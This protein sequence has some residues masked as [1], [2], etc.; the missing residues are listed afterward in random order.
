MKKIISIILPLYMLSFNSYA[1]PEKI[2]MIF[3]S[4]H[5]VSQLLELIE[6]N[7]AEKALTLLAEGDSGEERCIPMGDGC[8]DPQ[9]GYMEKK[10]KAVVDAT[11]AKIKMG[12][13]APPIV[14]AAIPIPN[15]PDIQ[16]KTFNAIETN[17]INCD[18]G[19]YF[20]IFCGKERAQ[21]KPAEI[22][23]W[24]DVSSS[25]RSVDYNKDPD[26]CN[27]RTFMT[28]VMEGCKDKVRVSV[29]NTALKEIGDFSSVCLSYGTNDEAK[30]LQWIK[31]S[32]AKKL[33]IVTDIDEV[34]K[35]M[36][37]YLDERGAKTVGDGVKAFNS[38]DLVNYASEFVKSCK[39]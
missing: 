26:R 25:L 9:Y 34:S 7:Q 5:K 2:E 17:M 22:E 38:T 10:P 16:L 31:D 24:F 27:R 1:A 28:K 30:L 29:Y 15:D 37:D 35:A 14:P 21:G 33:L 12:V 13:T 20:D 3:L 36:R 32:S 23:I 18:K 11:T 4:P 39:K 19:N 6:K 8:F